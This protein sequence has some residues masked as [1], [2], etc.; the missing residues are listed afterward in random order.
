MN[1]FYSS[2]ITQR[3]INVIYNIFTKK[4]SY[5]I[6]FVLKGLILSAIKKKIRHLLGFSDNMVGC[7]IVSH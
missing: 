4:T 1:T 3:V 6:L 2:L 5:N 7:L